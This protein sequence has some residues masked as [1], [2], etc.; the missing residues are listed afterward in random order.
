[1][2]N[3]LKRWNLPGE[4]HEQTVA[5]KIAE[6]DALGK[7]EYD[8]LGEV[9]SLHGSITGSSEPDYQGLNSARVRL[10]TR[11]L[12]QWDEPNPHRSAAYD[13]AVKAMCEAVLAE[14]HNGSWLKDFEQARR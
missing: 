10:I 2:C 6:M 8:L 9:S 14:Y 11:R 3:C 1:M 13:N 12:E 4:T 7:W 5:R